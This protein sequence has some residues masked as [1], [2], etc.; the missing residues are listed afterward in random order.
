MNRWIRIGIVFS[1]AVLWMDAIAISVSFAEDCA[2]LPKGPDRFSCLSRQKPGL[3]DK[4]ADKQERC[5]EAAA[6][7]GL[8]D[9]KGA[10]EYVAACMQ[11][12]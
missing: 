5:R 3:A 7:M 4:H 12:K 9:R 2:Q 11:K 10:N 8:A 1:A 6:G